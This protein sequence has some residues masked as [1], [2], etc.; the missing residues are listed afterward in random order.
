MMSGNVLSRPESLPM[1]S[2]DISSDDV[3]SDLKCPINILYH[4]HHCAFMNDMTDREYP[5]IAVILSVIGGVLILLS[6]LVI[7]FF[8]MSDIP[9]VPGF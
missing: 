3:L 8:G 6:G 1:G 2:V 5:T 4:H 9:G 7:L